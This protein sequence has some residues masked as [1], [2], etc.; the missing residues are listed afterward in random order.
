MI[1]NELLKYLSNS[2]HIWAF[3]TKHRLIVVIVVI[4]LY[5]H[6]LA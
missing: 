1:K 5:I 2:F 4:C 6:S 3:I